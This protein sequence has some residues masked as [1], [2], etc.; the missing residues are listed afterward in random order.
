MIRLTLDQMEPDL[1]TAASSVDDTSVK[2]QPPVDSQEGAPVPES[3]VT[4]EQ[5]SIS[6]GRFIQQ[7]ASQDAFP[8]HSNLTMSAPITRVGSYNMS[9]MANALPQAGYRSG[10]FVPGTHQHPYNM[11]PNTSPPVVPQHL[12]IGNQYGSHPAMPMPGHG[13]Y[14]QPQQMSQYYGGQMS[15]A[16]GQA[17]IPARQGI[18]YYPNQMMMNHSQPAFY[19][20][21]LTHFSGH[22]PMMPGR[23]LH[24]QYAE[25]PDISDSRGF[26]GS[27]ASSDF[28][29][30]R[31]KQE[32]RTQRCQ[33]TAADR[34]D[35]SGAEQ[36]RRQSTARGPPRKPRQSGES[37]L[38]MDTS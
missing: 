12:P 11:N 2:P 3:Q 30:Q 37:P 4:A 16:Q 27:H 15:P 17:S 22:S 1:T 18:G 29:Q 33:L 38:L 8:S 28:P 24:A 7:D 5:Q 36:S 32:L 6:N 10:S 20:A 31:A 13:Y 9:Q 14:I 19:F 21:Q 25:S 26:S 23:S 35:V 34:T